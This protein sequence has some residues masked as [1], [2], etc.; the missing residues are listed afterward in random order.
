MHI[1]SKNKAE[2]HWLGKSLRTSHHVIVSFD[3]TGVKKRGIPTELGSRS[4]NLRVDCVQFESN[5]ML[6]VVESCCTRFQNLSS[7]AS[8]QEPQYRLIPSSEIKTMSEKDKKNLKKM[9]AS[10]ERVDPPWLM[11]EVTGP[12]RHS[13]WRIPAWV[14]VADLWQDWHVGIP[15]RIGRRRWP[16]DPAS[17]QIK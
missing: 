6:F 3:I 7:P 10:D 9:E 11:H 4:T 8:A 2:W 13:L 5:T 14:I 16:V 17:I 1:V 12:S 15:G